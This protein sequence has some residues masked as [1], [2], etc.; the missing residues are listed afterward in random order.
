MKNDSLVYRIPEAIWS[1]ELP[2]D[3]VSKLTKYAQ[4]RWWSRESV[5]QLY[6]SNL[7]SAVVRTDKV[8]KLKSVFSSHTRVLLDLPAV[9]REREEYFRAG[10]HCLGFWHTHPEP[11]PD[12]SPEDRVMA[13]DHALAGRAQYTGL[14]FIIVGTAA[15]P[16][17]IGVWVHDGARL[18]QANS[19]SR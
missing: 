3:V 11:I 14:V 1:L 15:P 12:L 6:S 5:G 19:E 8:T 13:A 4:R 17:G 7:S 16:E 10:Y 18:W 2:S 9:E